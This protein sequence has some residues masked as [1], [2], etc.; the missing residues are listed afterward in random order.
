MLDRLKCNRTHP[1]E[2]CVKTGDAETCSFSLQA[3]HE[4]SQLPTDQRNFEGL[5]ARID[6]LEGLLVSVV[7]KDGVQH[8]QL[9]PHRELSSSIELE[10]LVYQSDG[11]IAIQENTEKA[12]GIEVDQLSPTFGVIQVDPK[13]GK[14]LYLG[15]AHWIS[16]MCEVGYFTKS[17]SSKTSFNVIDLI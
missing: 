3:S 4:E 7:T 11:Q 5:K 13:K 10:S 6:R 9:A 16:I 14:S 1:C 8:T 17:N 2:S 12:N 15:G